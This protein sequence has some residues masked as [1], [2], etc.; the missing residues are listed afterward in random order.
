MESYSNLVPLRY[1]ASVAHKTR[2]RGFSVYDYGL[3]V[4]R[5]PRKLRDEISDPSRDI[6]LF[7]INDL[8][9]GEGGI[10]TPGTVTRTPHFECGAIDHSATSPQ[11]KACLVWI[12]AR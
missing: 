8:N 5:K 1:C 4:A 11:Y 7:S 3:T 6:L 10:R 9:G 12:A 2:T